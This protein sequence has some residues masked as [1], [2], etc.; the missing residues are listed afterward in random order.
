MD[1][2]AMFMVAKVT[3]RATPNKVHVG[4]SLHGPLLM[5]SKK[6]SRGPH[7]V[8]FLEFSKNADIDYYQPP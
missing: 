8:H 5:W 7:E 2:A 1:F 3:V 6:S 4:R